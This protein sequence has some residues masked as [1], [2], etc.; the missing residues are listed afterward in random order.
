MGKRGEA[1]SSS[2]A[3][4][5]PGWKLWVSSR[6]GKGVFGRGKHAI[7][8]EIDRTGSLRRA[9]ENLGISYRKAWGDIRGAEKRLGRKLVQSV[10][11]GERGGFSRLT[12]F[13][14]R[15]L[16]AY[17]RYE[18]RVERFVTRAFE[19]EILPLLK[20]KPPSR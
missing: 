17:G 16:A 1:G 12:P 19:R 11:G 18:S 20:K 6:D 8:A 10:P 3:R 14:R 7:L 5:L 13:A 4:F 15:L 9:A 2:S